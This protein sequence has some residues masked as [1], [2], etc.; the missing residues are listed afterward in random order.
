M[1]TSISR[2]ITP[3]FIFFAELLFGWDLIIIYNILLIVDYVG[4]DG[5]GK[6]LLPIECVTERLL[7]ER[8]VWSITSVVWKRW[9]WTGNGVMMNLS[10]SELDAKVCKFVV[11]KWN[12]AFWWWD[13]ESKGCMVWHDFVNSA[14]EICDFVVLVSGGVYWW[15]EVRWCRWWNMERCCSRWELCHERLVSQWCR[16][17]D[18]VEG[19]YGVNDTIQ[20]ECRLWISTQWGSTS[21]VERACGEEGECERFHYRCFNK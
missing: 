18:R 10:G 8:L 13:I 11:W 3:I 9:S 14:G 1:L 19:K 4:W 15:R 12:Q 7:W 2:S 21:Q 5:S 16:E 20:L 6:G 17:R